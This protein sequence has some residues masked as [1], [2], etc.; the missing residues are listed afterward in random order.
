MI[1]AFF[2]FRHILNGLFNNCIFRYIQICR[3]I[4]NQAYIKVY[5]GIIHVH[6]EPCVTFIYSEVWYIQNSGI[7]KTR[8]IFRTLVYPKFWH[9]QNQRYI[10]TPGLLKTLGYS[11]PEVSLEPYIYDG[12]LWKIANGYNCFPNLKLFLQYQ[13]FMSS[14]S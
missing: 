4:I 8:G 14:S 6:S 2:H 11:E 1:A 3:D 12:A 9:I 7:F 13:L 10:K 5:W